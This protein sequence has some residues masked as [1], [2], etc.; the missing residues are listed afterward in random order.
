MPVLLLAQ[1]DQASRTLLRSAIEA[2]YGL[3]PPAL[4]TLTLRFKGRQRAHLG[5]LT[6]WAGLD[7]SVSFRF[8]LTVRWAS[9]ARRAGLTLERSSGSFD[10]QAVRRQQRDQVVVDA[11]APVATARAV[12]W[13]ACAVL[14]IPLSEAFVELKQIDDLS[15][16]AINTEA[17]V[18]ARLRLNQDSSLASVSTDCINP[19]DG[20]TETFTIELA[21]GLALL[22]DLILPRELKLLW[23]GAPAYE[24]TPISAA[25]NEPLDD[26]FF[27]LEHD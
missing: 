21:D 22:D 25:S 14:L 27:R 13:A 19:A 18:T 6:L 8:P 12:L 7:G 4:E 10:D 11:T 3:G 20:Q 26:G 2:R 5:P 1:G 9:T 24:L 17:G 16:D 23:N 15:F